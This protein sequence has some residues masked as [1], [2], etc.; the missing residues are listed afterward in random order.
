MAISNSLKIRDCFVAFAPRNDKKPH[1]RTVHK[2]RNENEKNYSYIIALA[3]FLG[4]ILLFFLTTMFL[5]IPLG[6]A[7]GEEMA[8]HDPVPA[9]IVNLL[10]SLMG[11]WAFALLSYLQTP[12]ALWFAVAVFGIGAYMAT[13]D[14]LTRVPIA[15]FGAVLVAL[16]ILGQNI[17]WS[18]YHRLET[19]GLH[20]EREDDHEPVNVGYTLKVQQVFYQVAIDLSDP[21]LLIDDHVQESHLDYSQP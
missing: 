18:P 5:F 11:I 4:V 13:R 14:E 1:F 16:I 15:I 9:Y 2:R 19:Q 21:E 17:L 3:L 12:P 20:L 8:R 10:A 6:Q 7:T